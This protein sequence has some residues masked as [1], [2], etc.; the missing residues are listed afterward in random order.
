M[1]KITGFDKLQGQL[2]DAQKALEGLD[3]EMGTVSFNPRGP[4]SIEAA[5]QEMERL[6]DER[7][8]AY[9]GN[10]FI[11]PLAEEMK[12][13][14]RQGILDKAAARLRP[15]RGVMATVHGPV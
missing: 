9:P 8:G 12:T 3:G 10:P 2:R 1:I 13:V 14:F 15:W 11:G 6:V 7:V 4:A 5:V